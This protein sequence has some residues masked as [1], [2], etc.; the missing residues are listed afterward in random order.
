MKKHGMEV[1]LALW[2]ICPPTFAATCSGHF[3]N[4]VLDI[5]WR[6]LFP[7]TI[8]SSRVA[9]GDLPDTD[10]PQKTFCVCQGGPFPKV[11]FTLGY[12]EPMAL[13]DITRTPYCFV[14]LGGLHL[15]HEQQAEG[16]VET[17]SPD[18]NGSFYYVHVY[19]F[20]I[21]QWVGSWL[22]GGSCQTRGKFE[23][24]YFSELD[25]TWRDENLALITFP[26]T[27]NF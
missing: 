10:N 24:V 11:G 20:P 13:V 26:E 27:I 25:P 17:Q 5:C 15:R 3:I 2:I 8:G 6:C 12:W 18:Q 19:H 9:S 1:F 7:I 14:N 4:P 21:L 16:A 23:V 22:L